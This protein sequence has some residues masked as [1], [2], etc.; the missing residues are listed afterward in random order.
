MTAPAGDSGPITEGTADA[1]APTTDA[2]ADATKVIDWEAET[3]KVRQEAAKHRTDKN[4]FKTQAEELQTRIEGLEGFQDKYEASL[5]ETATAT[6]RL[7]R[8]TAAIEARMEPE[9]ILDMADLLKGSTHEEWV[10]HAKSLAS[11]L[12]NGKKSVD[13]SQGA[14]SSPNQ[15]FTPFGAFVRKASQ[16][17]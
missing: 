16:G 14:A 3:K 6:E 15:N 10:E 13:P 2:P 9:D 5:A 4:Q 17:R 7:G 1:E 12:K 11:R 8:L